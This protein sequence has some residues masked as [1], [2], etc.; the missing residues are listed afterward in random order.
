[1]ASGS[2][3]TRN[4]IKMIDG[5]LITLGDPTPLE[6]GKSLITGSDLFKGIESKLNN[7]FPGLDWIGEAAEKYSGQN[8]A[9]QLRMKSMA[10]FDKLTN[11]FVS[12][13]AGYIQDARDTLHNIRGHAEGLL[14]FCVWCEDHLWIVGD[15]ISWAAAVPTNIVFG[16]IVG[17]AMLQLTMKTLNNA[18]N[19]TQ[20]IPN[21]ISML[22]SLPKLADFI[23]GLLPDIK[24]PDFKW[25]PDF[26][27]P[28]IKWPDFKFPDFKW[29]EIP[30]FPGFPEIKFPDFKLP[31]FKFPGLDGL[32]K[33]PDLFPGLP[34]LSDLFGGA[35][36]RLPSWN[37][38]ANLP[39][40]LGGV[41]G[42]P[43]M[44]FSNMLG[45]ASMPTF[46]Q[47]TST[48]SQLTQLAGGGGGANMLQSVGGQAGGLTSLMSAGGG[49]GAQSATL[50]SD[51]KKDDEEGAGAGTT[52]GER[53]PIDGGG[54]TGGQTQQGRVL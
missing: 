40:F 10:S 4:T 9:Q 5:L 39:D 31:D 30:K 16:I 48:L 23:S 21:L 37:E 36:P 45:L 33:L 29:P 17:N 25:P 34:K 54:G 22:T 27:L 3:I 19:L 43:K 49:G 52:G 50:V 42:L 12:N 1:M 24:L 47:L 8:L 51:V 53:A 6:L 38:L 32:P 7:T 15:A 35:I 44:N 2:Q 28:D 11:G 26:K 14:S 46:N 13:Q 41:L 18:T 20:L